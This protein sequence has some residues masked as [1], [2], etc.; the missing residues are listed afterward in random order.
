MTNS[1]TNDI[2]EK[3]PPW[4]LK[5]LEALE[6]VAY[7]AYADLD[8]DESMS[9]LFGAITPEPKADDGF[10]WGVLHLPEDL[11]KYEAYDH[12]RAALKHLRETGD[13]HVLGGFSV[14]EGWE[15]DAESKERTG[16]EMLILNIESPDG[17][18]ATKMLT[19][20]RG[21]ADITLKPTMTQINFHF[22]GEADGR[23]QGM[24]DEPRLTPQ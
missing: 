9:S 19:I 20:V 11:D 7:R 16:R 4:I 13:R 2:N 1:D 21:G 23:M 24:F 12:F 10:A 15:L 18:R 5:A 17:W 14:N 6:S 8:G 22:P 3:A